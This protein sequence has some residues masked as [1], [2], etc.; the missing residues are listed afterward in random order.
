MQILAGVQEQILVWTLNVEVE[1]KVGVG[2]GESEPI[3]SPQQ[4]QAF[5]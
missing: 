4:Q 1:S 2:D 5:Q 3:Y